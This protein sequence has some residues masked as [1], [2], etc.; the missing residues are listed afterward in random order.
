ME[1]GHRRRVR[2]QFDGIAGDLRIEVLDIPDDHEFM[3][4]ELVSL[5]KE[6]VEPWIEDGSGGDTGAR[7]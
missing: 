4:P 2:E 1:H 6:R 3:D 5:I 7:R